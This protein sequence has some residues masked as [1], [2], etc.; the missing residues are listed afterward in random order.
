MKITLKY[1]PNQS[2]RHGGEV[3]LVICHTPEGSDFGTIATIMNPAEQVSYHRLYLA[4][5]EEA[6]QFVPFEKK[7]WHAKALNSVS[8]GLACSGY[9]RRFDLHKAETREFAKGVAERLKARNLQPQWTTD[10][11]KGGFCRHAD[12]QSDRSDPTPDIEEWKEF[13][14]MVK[15]AYNKESDLYWLWLAWTLGE[16]DFAGRGK[17]NP[18]ARPAKLPKRVPVS[19]WARRAAFLARRNS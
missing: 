17:R 2:E 16:G 1:S 15:A 4:G 3:R 18:N 6:I 7:A 14:K 5:G 8:D 11:A 10:L 19:W 13:C 12:L 9:A